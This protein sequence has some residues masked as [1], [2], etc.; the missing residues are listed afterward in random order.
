VSEDARWIFRRDRQPYLFRPLTIRSVTLRNRIVLSPMCQYSGDDGLPTDWHFSHLA[1]RAVGGAGLIFTEATNVESRGRITRYCLGLWNERQRDAFARIAAFVSTQ[2]AVPGIQLGHAGRKA[3]TNRPWEGSQPI[4]EADGG[5]EAIAPTADPYDARFSAPHA[6]TGAAINDVLAATAN[7]A[8]LARE[9]GFKV[10][11]L[12]AAHGYLVHQ[13]LS[14]VVNTRS[15]TYG[16]S[17]AHRSRFLMEMLDAI[18]SQWPSDLPLFVRLSCTD[19]IAGGWTLDDTIE[20]TRRLAVRG[21]VDLIDCSSGGIAPHQQVNVYPGYQ[22]PFARTVRERS[23]MATAA[24]GLIH[25]ADM[26]E[27]IVAGGDADLV[28]LGRTLLADPQ[29]PLR[30]ARTLHAAI[31]W[32]VQY[33]RANIF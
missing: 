32:P 3:S 29:W 16:G 7:A 1:A 12:H 14:P 17:L 9:A 31:E 27:Q 2:G 23:G 15:D 5:W 28:M 20:M 4:S 18:R 25:A 19:W 11:E 13:F 8:R 26:A 30:A 10:V 33:E 21:D 6:M 24:V 22:I